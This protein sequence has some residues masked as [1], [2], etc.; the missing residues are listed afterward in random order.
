MPV[1]WSLLGS[2]LKLF[3]PRIPDVLS[4]IQTMR[5]DRPRE[6]SHR[7]ETE[8]RLAK[9]ESTQG[10]YLKALEQLTTQLVALQ[11]TIR[12]L[13]VLTILALVLS[14]MALVLTLIRS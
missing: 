7:Q 5:Q 11:T 8:A 13:M 4:T 1:P 14:I 9:L 2:L 12:G 3:G 6:E 10:K